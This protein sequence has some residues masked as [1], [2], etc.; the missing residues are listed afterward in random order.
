MF[1]SYTN[2]LYLQLAT[3]PNIIIYIHR[4]TGAGR[5]LIGS[6]YLEAL[7][8]RY[9][10]RFAR[11]SA[12]LRSVDSSTAEATPIDSPPWRP[13]PSDAELAC[14]LRAAGSA[15]ELGRSFVAAAAVSSPAVLRL[16]RRPNTPGG[17]TSKGAA[18]AAAV[19]A[20]LPLAPPPP[21]PQLPI[22][23]HK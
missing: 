10:K 1:I 9:A 21:P 22:S 14:S 12:R 11:N 5:R 23:S 6:Y 17:T 18:A 7:A 2:M 15:L 19:A 4:N 13:R 20:L 8:A 16:Q 3:T